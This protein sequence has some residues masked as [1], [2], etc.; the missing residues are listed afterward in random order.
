[1]S[2]LLLLP[3]LILS[4]FAIDIGSFYLRASELQTASDLASL[5][6]AEIIKE[7]GTENDVNLAV[8]KILTSNGV[9]PATIDYQVNVNNRTVSVIINDEDVRQFL[10][11]IIIDKVD[12]QREATATTTDCPG[13]TNDITLSPTQFN[14]P[15]RG[16]GDGFGPTIVNHNG[17]LKVFALNHHEP[18]N[19]YLQAPLN[20]QPREYRGAPNTRPQLVCV[21]MVTT[22]FCPGYPAR[23]NTSTSDATDLAWYAPNE[24]I[25]YTAVR[26]NYSNSSS[27]RRENQ[28]GNATT[29]IGFGCVNASTG[30]DCTTG[31][32]HLATTAPFGP[33]FQEGG[34][35]AP[36]DYSDFA[37]QIKMIDDKL[38][39]ID[40][41]FNVHCFDPAAN[42]NC[43]SYPKAPSAWSNARANSVQGNS[44]TTSAG[45]YDHLFYSEVSGGKIYA[46]SKRDVSGAILTGDFYLIC[47]DPATGNSCSGFGSTIRT[48]SGGLQSLYSNLGDDGVCLFGNFTTSCI[49]ESGNASNP[50]IESHLPNQ[51][52][53]NTTKPTR[54]GDRLY[55]G[56]PWISRTY[57]V[58]LATRT[59]CG[60]ITDNQPYSYEQ[61]PGQNCIASLGHASELNFF[62]FDLQPCS[63]QGN[64]TTIDPCTCTDG[65]EQ[66][67]SITFESSFIAMFDEFLVTIAENEENG[68]VFIDSL[69]LV[70]SNGQIDLS[71][72]P[73]T[74]DSLKMTYDYTLNQ[75]FSWTQTVTGSYEVSE[76]A[77][78]I[79]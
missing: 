62:D 71:N 45:L 36:G 60:N 42:T 23:L 78:L 31:G 25:W 54:I 77:V 53:R 29:S 59:S 38:Y 4:A 9:D 2:A 1:M 33:T 35:A 27:A 43:A 66:W 72:I 5:A 69:D 46:I 39:I 22:D 73:D 26:P 20:G 75:N 48:V 58:N 12:V 37:T 76:R 17:E 34:H 63:P 79:K 3:L 11:K 13:C 18:S 70:A 68:P 10:S 19:Q 21:S 16:N 52:D 64:F 44:A 65:S 67:G 74:V 51:N 49:D 8:E 55:V 41:E 30:T 61:V 14:L 40:H 6:G 47:F 7:G 32:F 57:C 28:L 15:D 56:A 24:Q 50:G